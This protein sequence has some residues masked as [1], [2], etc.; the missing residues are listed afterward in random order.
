MNGSPCKEIKGKVCTNCGNKM[1]KGLL[2]SAGRGISRIFLEIED[3]ENNPSSNIPVCVWFC[4]HC[5]QV[6]LF[7]D[8]TDQDT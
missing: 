3:S 8:V 1:E 4:R 2:Q 7:A 6:L 5:G